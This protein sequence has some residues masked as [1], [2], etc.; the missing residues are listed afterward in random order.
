MPKMYK[1]G[2]SGKKVAKGAFQPCPRCPSPSACR[3][4]GKC[5]AQSF[6]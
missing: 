3:K 6:G 1:P 2:K 5:I 4:A